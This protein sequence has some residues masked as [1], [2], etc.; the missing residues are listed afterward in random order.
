MRALVGTRAQVRAA[1]QRLHAALGLPRCGRL[2]GVATLDGQP[3]PSD[4]C[5]CTDV[6]APTPSCRFATRRAHPVHRMRVGDATRWAIVMRDARNDARLTAAQRALVSDIG[7][8]DVEIA[9]A[10]DP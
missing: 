6:A 5:Q 8:L 1:A 2:A 7:E 10:E 9:E 3:P 4:A